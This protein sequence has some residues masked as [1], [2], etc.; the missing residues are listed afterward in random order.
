MGIAKRPIR[1]EGA[2]AIIPLTKGYEAVIDVEDVPLVEGKN[3]I[4]LEDR[5]RD[6]KIRNVYAYR[7]A[8]DSKGKRSTVLLHREITGAPPDLEVDH[9]DGNGL[10]NRRRGEAGN[11]RL[12]TESENQ[13]N[14]RGHRNSRSGL[15]G[16]SWHTKAGKWRARVSA[17]GKDQYCELFVC[18]ARAI[19]AVKR[20]RR[21]LPGDF[22][23][24]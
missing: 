17:K 13:H 19:I 20:E 4:A 14:R 16:L 21:R 5:Y 7:A 18:L 6:G 9:R 24:D 23:R 12:V 3:W 2:V 8:Q 10:N 15:K 11:L 1:I 22:A